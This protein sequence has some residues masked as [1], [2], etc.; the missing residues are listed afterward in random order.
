MNLIKKLF[1]KKVSKD[2]P[3]MPPWETIVEMM[4]DKDL[5][6]F[7][8][9]VAMVLYSKDRSKR[10]VVLKYEKGHF[11]YQFEVICQY[12]EEEWKYVHPFDL[13]AT[14]EPTF[15]ENIGKSY[16]ENTEDLLRE[17]KSEPAYRMYFE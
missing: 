13:P 14:W 17:I 9:E 6:C 8:G 2:I 4:Y 10:Y 15:D 3:P 1:R 12:D 16:F 11:T 5:D 7:D